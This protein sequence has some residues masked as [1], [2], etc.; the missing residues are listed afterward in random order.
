MINPNQVTLTSFGP[1]EILVVLTCII[2]ALLYAFEV[3]IIEHL[4]YSKKQHTLAKVFGVGAESTQN[5]K[6]F[7]L[8]GV[9]RKVLA[10][11]ASSGLD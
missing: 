5:F 2:Y 4:R 10:W 1:S 6:S 7:S 9:T 3:L 8:M 11:I